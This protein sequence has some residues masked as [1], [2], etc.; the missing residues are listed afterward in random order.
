MS[1]VKMMVTLAAWWRHKAE[2]RRQ[3]QAL[4]RLDERMLRG[5]GIRPCDAACEARKP[6][7]R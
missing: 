1:I 5:I 4:S 2:V 3:R 7:W 6:F